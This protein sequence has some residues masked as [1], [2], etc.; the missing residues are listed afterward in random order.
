MRAEMTQLQQLGRSD[1]TVPHCPSRLTEEPGEPTG[2]QPVWVW[3]G[4]PDQQFLRPGVPRGLYRRRFLAAFIK[5]LPLVLT[6][7]QTQDQLL[8]R[9]P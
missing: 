5:R 9:F 2:P 3:T 4:T 7:T 8:S 1:A 6:H